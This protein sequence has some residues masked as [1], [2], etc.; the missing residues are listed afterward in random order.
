MIHKR[1]V[2]SM[3]NQRWF[4]D[5]IEQRHGAALAVIVYSIGETVDFG[6]DQIVKIA[7]AA[8]RFQL[9]GLT[10]SEPGY[11]SSLREALAFNKLSR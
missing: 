7:N 3:D 6:G 9:G 11:A 4:G 10:G 5:P 8:Q 2:F 1:I